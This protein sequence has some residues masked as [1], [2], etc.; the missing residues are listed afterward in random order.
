M[1]RLLY[2]IERAKSFV[3]VLHWFFVIGYR[4]RAQNVGEEQLAG[5]ASTCTTLPTSETSMWAIPTVH[6]SSV[7]GYTV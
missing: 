5:D 7:G 1:A 6:R 3:T 2:H 4:W